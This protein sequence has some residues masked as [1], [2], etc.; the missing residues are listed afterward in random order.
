MLYKPQF[1]SVFR[2][3]IVE[4][5]GLIIVSEKNAFVLKG[6]LAQKIAPLIN[7]Q[8]TVDDIITQLQNEFSPNEIYDI[9]TLMEEKGYL[10]EA[11]DILP[12]P[13]TA[14]WETLN[15]NSKLLTHR[16]QTTKVAIKC[17]G[18]DSQ[19][20][21]MSQLHSQLAHAL[22]SLQIQ[23]VEE[24]DFE[25]ICTDDYLSGELEHYN[26]R[27]LQSQKPWLLVKPVGTT[28]WLGPIFQPSQ[29]GCW[30][31]LAQ[32]LRG[33]RPIESFIQRHN[34]TLI[35]GTAS[36]AFLPSTLQTA[37]SMIATAIAQWIIEDEYQPLLGKM[38]TLDSQSL[39]IQKHQ[40]VK[41]PQCPSCGSPEFYSSSKLTPIV[42][43]SHYKTF[44]ADG[45]YRCTYP[46][47]TLKNNQHH[48]SSLLGV[49]RELRENSI[50]DDGVIHTYIAPHNFASFYDDF[51]SLKK[52]L[53]GI[54]AGKG[55]TPKQAQA[56]GFCEAVERY[57]GVFQGDELRITDSLQ[58]MGDKA[59]H[60][61]VCMLY[62]Q[63]Q[64][65]NR[66]ILN[67]TA[68]AKQWIPEPF[69]PERVIEW[70]PVWSLTEEK[71]KYLPTAYCYYGYRKQ[72]DIICVADSNG[73]A[74]GN[75]LEE[76]IL[77]GFMEVVERDCVAMWWYNCIR[78]P[79]VDLTSFQE[80]YFL[81]IK[82]Y[83][84]RLNRD[85]WV[86]DLS[87]DLKIP[88]FAAVSR[89]NDQSTEEIIYGFGSHFD[90]KLAIMRALT[91]TNQI[92][93]NLI[94]NKIS[95]NTQP[96]SD[97]LLL[98]WLKEAKVSN[99]L[100]LAVDSNLPLKVSTD[101]PQRLFSNDLRD[102]IF[103]C[104][105]ILTQHNLEM[106][107]LDQSRPDIDLN[108][109]KVIVPGLR[110]FWQRFAPGRLYDIPVQL[111]WLSETIPEHQINPNPIV[112]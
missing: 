12:S 54:S 45:G 44:T 41:R 5:E 26:Q 18:F 21:L 20:V 29:T 13:T 84:A 40:L 4:G 2:V 73:C 66:Q 74:S 86:L 72:D 23:V 87:N 51:S 49:V 42:L 68:A 24:G 16:S 1:K 102:D 99:Q 27:N 108:V 98:K 110:H 22:T 109:V 81:E 50:A 65:A 97:N 103:M 63:E 79:G 8:H 67:K 80:P 32:R 61:N 60:P 9:L 46:E 52:N 111:G 6:N 69:N 75:T 91:E 106:L 28:L 96:P 17:V 89:R 62:S 43:S 83:Y 94:Y 85:L 3:E 77:Q 88:T 100:Y 101:Y 64:Y 58:K 53:R 38:V 56:S 82:D 107:V 71:F 14:F 15:I 25:I 37:V 93:S 19:N 47:L 55:R 30:Q 11:E 78:K 95:N 7:A 59:I 48:I 90:P 105:D 36:Q 33:N 39:N 104:L 76:A 112:I 92:L 10:I 31:C 35:S 70:T 57:C 34:S